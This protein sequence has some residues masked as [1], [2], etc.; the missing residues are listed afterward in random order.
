MTMNNKGT[1]FQALPIIQVK[2]VEA[3]MGGQKPI[4]KRNN[5]RILFWVTP[6]FGAYVT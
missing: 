2:A 5:N 4:S 1:A 6:R 3:K